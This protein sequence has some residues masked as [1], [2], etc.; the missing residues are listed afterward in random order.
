MK[1]KTNFKNYGEGEKDWGEGLGWKGFNATKSKVFVAPNL[2]M[3]II[4]MD[5]ENSGQRS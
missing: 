2:F 3:A 1:P 4:I 5:L